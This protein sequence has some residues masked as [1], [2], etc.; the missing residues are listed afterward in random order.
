MPGH[1]SVLA[2]QP[3][4][5][6]VAVLFVALLIGLDLGRLGTLV[7]GSSRGALAAAALTFAVG[8][9]FASV[10]MGIAI[11]QL[12]EDRGRREPRPV[13]G[14]YALALVPARVGG[15]G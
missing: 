13:G 10:R 5:M 7:E 1:V 15:T 9:T 12:G 14:G 11:M 4:G 8:P 6:G 2:R 3:L